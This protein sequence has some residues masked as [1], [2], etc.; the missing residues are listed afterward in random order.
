MLI[1]LLERLYPIIGQ[2]AAV[3]VILQ[4]IFAEYMHGHLLRSLLRSRCWLCRKKQRRPRM[5]SATLGRHP[6][7]SRGQTHTS[8][9]AWGFR[10]PM[11]AM[12]HSSHQKLGPPCDTC[13]FPIQNQSSF[14]AHISYTKPFERCLNMSHSSAQP[15]AASARMMQHPSLHNS[16]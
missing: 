5:I 4:L 14:D 3:K 15:R 1:L 9:R 12:L 13:V 6:K 2:T 10:S 7:Q 16:I 11:A 8:Q